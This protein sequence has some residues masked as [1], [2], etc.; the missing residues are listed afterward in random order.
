MLTCLIEEALQD[1]TQDTGET[2]ERV[3]SIFTKYT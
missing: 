1:Q 3:R 2:L